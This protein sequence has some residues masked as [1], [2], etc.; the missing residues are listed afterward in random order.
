MA[1]SLGE[2]DRVIAAGREAAV[3]RG[4]LVSLAVVEPGGT[5]VSFARMDGA[6][7]FTV[8]SAKRK[9]DLAV[10]LG[11]DTVHMSAPG[12]EGQPLFGGPAPSGVPALVPNGGGV[13]I[14][15]DGRVIGALGVSGAEFSITDHQIGTAAVE[16]L[17]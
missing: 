2:A 11:F 16:R 14:R 6:P 5:L 15:A 9:A 17:S 8:D 13:I 4:E 3:E 12:A 1:I 10:A 7:T